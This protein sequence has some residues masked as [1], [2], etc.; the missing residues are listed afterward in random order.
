MEEE[1]LDML[2]NEKEITWQVLLYNVIKQEKMD[3]WDINVS[4][5]THSYIKSIKKLKDLDLNL[6]GKVVLA[7][8]L[9]LKMKSTRLVGEDMQ[10]LDKI[11]SSIQNSEIE[12]IQE[13]EDF[14]Q[15]LSLSVDNEQINKLAIPALLPKTP[16]PRRRKVSMYDLMDALEKALEVKERRIIKKKIASSAAIT[17]PKPKFN[18]RDMI[19]KVYLK[20]RDLFKTQNSV[21]FSDLLTED[22]KEEKVYTFIP[23]LHLA[24]QDESKI[25]LNQ[26]MPF[27][28]IIISPY[29]KGKV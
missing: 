24:H 7:A 14:Y 13:F 17:I 22:N 21:V 3:I 27:G 5:I 2:R 19:K 23:L 10:D 15:G 8:A 12:E 20:L 11:F 29:S 1:I 26:G 28:E 6:S 16:Q 18:M 4:K 9:L 25:T